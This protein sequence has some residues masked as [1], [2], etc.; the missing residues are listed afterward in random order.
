[1]VIDT[2][3]TRKHL[4]QFNF[5]TISTRRQHPPE[6]YGVV[7]M[8][9]VPDDS[10]VKL[11]HL[12]IVLPTYVC[13]IFGRMDPKARTA[14]LDQPSWRAA[15]CCPHDFVSPFHSSVECPYVRV[16]S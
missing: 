3:G 14:V 10:D 6:F 16:A 5:E 7:R 13:S 9:A 2:S 4:T 8:R 1:M 15:K 12:K 11:S